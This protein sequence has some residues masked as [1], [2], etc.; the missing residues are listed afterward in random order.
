MNSPSLSSPLQGHVKSRTFREL[1]FI[2]FVMALCSLALLCAIGAT[3]YF[4]VTR[5]PY[6]Q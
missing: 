1:I 4:L 6:Q 3:V 5:W 2:Y